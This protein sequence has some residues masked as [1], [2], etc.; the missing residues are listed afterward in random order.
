MIVGPGVGAGVGAVVGTVVG[1]DVDA[2]ARGGA[3]VS[4]AGVVGGAIAGTIV[5]GETWLVGSARD[6]VSRAMLS[7]LEMLMPDGDAA[8]TV[9]VV[10]GMAVSAGGGAE[11]DFVAVF[12]RLLAGLGDP[13]RRSNAV[14]RIATKAVAPTPLHT[15][16]AIGARCGLVPHHLHSPRVSR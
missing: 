11:C 14:A 6:V 12:V 16:A 3:F 10:L 5:S 1:A 8:A 7:A 9:V 13:S 2:T 15:L 4:F